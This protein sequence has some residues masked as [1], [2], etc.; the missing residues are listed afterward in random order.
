METGD[1]VE[2][3]VLIILLVLSGFFSS[4]ETALTTVSLNKL[5]TIADEGGRRG[6]KA[7]LILKMR[8]DSGRLLSA[9][10]IGNNV[11]N[12]AASSLTTVLCTKLFGS[13][14]VGLAAGILTLFV[15]V[16][17]EITPKTLAAQYNVSLSMAF[18]RPIHFLMIIF[19]PI[20]WI[21]NGISGLI[22]KVFRIDP[23]VDPN[24]MT[25]SELLKIVDVSS[26]EGVIETEERKMITNVVDSLV[27]I[28][29][30]LTLM[31][32]FRS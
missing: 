7:K 21:V 23:D 24:K 27:R 20:I 3:I 8:E 32:R 11:V 15:L 1:I 22:F 12:I 30:A 28:W 2:L 16:F 31:H 29:S 6:K 14:F 26:D 18:A 25:E 5:R 17:G 19:T 10:L 4:S 9:I 13:S